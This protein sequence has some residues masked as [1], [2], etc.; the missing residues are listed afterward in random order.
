[1]SSYG[2]WVITPRKELGEITSLATADNVKAKVRKRVDQ[3]GD[4]KLEWYNGT[5]LPHLD[6]MSVGSMAWEDLLSAME[7]KGAGTEFRQFNQD[8]C[9]CASL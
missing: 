7:S 8:C 1:M 4:D 6:S 5:F 3:F 2:F 9:T